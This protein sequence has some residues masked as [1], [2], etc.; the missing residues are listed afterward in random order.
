MPDIA[1]L[2]RTLGAFL[3]T[4][5]SMTSCRDGS[6][7][8]AKIGTPEWSQDKTLKFD[9][10]N[11]DLDTSE[12]FILSIGHTQNYAYSNLYIQFIGLST[13]FDTLNQSVHSFELMN[14]QGEWLGKKKSNYYQKDFQLDFP[15]S[16]R[17][18]AL[19]VRQF[20]RD[21]ILHGVKFI[22]LSVERESVPM[23]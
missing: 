8:I 6:R 17:I 22:A 1:F 3:L 12:H 9:L 10:E 16:P 13:T 14:N 19:H 7:E 5:M 4:L 2:N 23:K 15:I 11:L 20:S 18:K 21:S